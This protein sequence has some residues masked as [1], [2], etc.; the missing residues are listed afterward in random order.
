M[1]LISV[2]V[3]LSRNKLRLT[4]VCRHEA[5]YFVTT[6]CSVGNKTCGRAQS[7]HCNIMSWRRHIIFVNIRFRELKWPATD[8]AYNSLCDFRVISLLQYRVAQKSADRLVKYVIKCVVNFF[9]THWIYKNCLKWDSPCSVHNC[10]CSDT[11]LKI[12]WCNMLWTFHLTF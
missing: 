11:V 8:N 5:V 1:N 3:A 6:D 2:G 9:V 7:L 12:D 10:L 4:S